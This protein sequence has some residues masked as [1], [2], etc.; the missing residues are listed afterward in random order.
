MDISQHAKIQS[1]P[2]QRHVY[3]ACYF[4]LFSWSMT[5]SLLAQMVM[6]RW[7]A[8]PSCNE[9]VLNPLLRNV[10]P[11]LSLSLQCMP[12]PALCQ[13]CIRSDQTNEEETYQRTWLLCNNVVLRKATRF[14]QHALQQ[15]VLCAILGCSHGTCCCKLQIERHGDVTYNK[16]SS[17]Q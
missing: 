5:P 16:M 9:V 2:L 11:S 10:S 1:T 14:A 12:L 8:E 6:S 15:G 17:L 4:R 3:I 7:N 13:V